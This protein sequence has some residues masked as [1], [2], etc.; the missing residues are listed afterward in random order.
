MDG[1]DQMWKPYKF[2]LGGAG[3]TLL[4]IS[5]LQDTMV[6]RALCLLSFLCRD[7]LPA[8]AND[9]CSSQTGL[10]SHACRSSRS[11][12]LYERPP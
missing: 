2:L 4:I 5:K 1:C 9:D 10:A 7:C 8:G 6:A 11:R 12:G 3:L